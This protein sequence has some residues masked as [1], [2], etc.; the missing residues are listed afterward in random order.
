VPEQSFKL[1]LCS[2]FTLHEYPWILV[3]GGLSDQ[4][5]RFGKVHP[6]LAGYSGK[7]MFEHTSSP[8]MQMECP[9]LHLLL[10]SL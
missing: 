5:Y 3:A 9:D 2:G 10:E 6:A 8:F 4:V 7:C 1:L